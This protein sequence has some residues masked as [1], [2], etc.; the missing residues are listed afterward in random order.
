MLIK[1]PLFKINYIS[2]TTRRNLTCTQRP[3]LFFQ[4]IFFVICISQ[5]NPTYTKSICKLN[6]NIENAIFLQTELTQ[7]G[8]TNQSTN[9]SLNANSQASG[10][11][12]N[13][14]GGAANV[15]SIAITNA[16]GNSVNN[17]NANGDINTSSSS[18]SNA[19]RDGLSN[20]NSNAVTNSETSAVNYGDS[21]TK[22]NNS[23]VS[24]S[25]ARSGTNIDHSTPKIVISGNYLG[26]P[27]DPIGF[28]FNGPIIQN[29]ANKIAWG[30][31]SFYNNNEENNQII[32]HSY[33]SWKS[34]YLDRNLEINY[35]KKFI[36]D[37]STTDLANIEYPEL[38]LQQS[39][40]QNCKS[41]DGT[42]INWTYTEAVGVDIGMD[43]Q[44]YINAVGLDGFLYEYN[45]LKNSWDKVK[46]YPEIQ[47]L[48]RVDVGQNETPYVV[49]SSG[50]AFFLSCDNLWERLP[51]CARDIGTG[52]GGEVFKIGC[53]RRESGYKIYKLNCKY[54]NQE[55]KKC[56]RYRK[57]NNT[58]YKYTISGKKCSWFGVD[59]G[60]VRISVHP[61]GNP[62]V[63]DD[64]QNI[65]FFDGIDWRNIPNIKALDLSL[66]NEGLLFYVGSDW[67]VNRIITKKYRNDYTKVNNEKLLDLPAIAIAAGPYSQPTIISDRYKIYTSSKLGYN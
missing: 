63:I 34:I 40:K 5:L 1:E 57:N 30:Q 42:L 15:N 60:G 52:R 7:P 54:Q 46:G 22:I 62:F 17:S 37:A 67:S 45:M 28:T 36:N 31:Q 50:E 66:S 3:F 23:A 20:A 10:L 44:G 19:S 29:L 2:L 39:Y 43:S 61:N 11:I 18:V 32:T 47:N 53:E 56:F 4:L 58:K 16:S 27:I 41:N 21:T 65:I 38:N 14:F 13:S 26:N 24:F 35:H 55:C 48:V 33:I 8:S 59:G 49:N 64:N 9:L 12:T 6:K 51:G 25:N